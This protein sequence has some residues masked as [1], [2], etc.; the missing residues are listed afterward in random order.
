ML[1]LSVH[2][3]SLAEKGKHCY[4]SW[5]LLDFGPQLLNTYAVTPI[6]GSL[7]HMGSFLAIT[8]YTAN[9]Q[10]V[11]LHPAH[12]QTN[13]SCYLFRISKDLWLINYALKIMILYKIYNCHLHICCYIYHDAYISELCA[14]PIG[15]YPAVCVFR[16]Y[17]RWYIRIK[18]IL[19]M[20][21]H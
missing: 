16:L 5:F 3:Y 11:A 7:I 6:M 9:S 17:H 1:S 20:A 2:S 4:R 12:L 13:Y 10:C 21:L 15:F 14:I 8:N 18:S 19:S